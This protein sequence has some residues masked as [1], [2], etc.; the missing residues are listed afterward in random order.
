MAAVLG[1]LV[2]CVLQLLRIRHTSAHVMAM[3]VQRL[4]PHVQVTIG[5]WIENGFYYDFYTGETRF[6]EE[7]LTAIKKEMDKIIKAKL[8]LRREEVRWAHK[9]CYIAVSGEVGGRTAADL[10]V[11][12]CGGA[13]GRRL[14]AGS[15]RSTSPTSSR[16]S[17]ASR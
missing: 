13:A 8:P 16:S 9:S 3:A 17:T 4:F 12:L 5:P 6:T 15:R 7:D 14:V 10:V 2:V 1:L 11:V